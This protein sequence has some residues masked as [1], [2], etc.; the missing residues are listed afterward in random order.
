M[1]NYAFFFR[2]MLLRGCVDLNYWGYDGK[3][4]ILTERLYQLTKL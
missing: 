1:L 2:W 4:L 3:I